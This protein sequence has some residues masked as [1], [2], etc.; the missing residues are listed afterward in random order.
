MKSTS[1]DEKIQE[2]T[3]LSKIR[4]AKVPKRRPQILFKSLI[5]LEKNKTGQRAYN[6][7]PQ[8]LKS[9]VSFAKLSHSDKYKL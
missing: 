1:F 5:I 3:F 8:V 7:W 9:N 4:F 2:V 6:P